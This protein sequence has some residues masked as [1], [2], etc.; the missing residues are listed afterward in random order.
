M[1]HER[2]GMEAMLFACRG[3]VQQHGAPFYAITTERV[4]NFLTLVTT[5]SASELA[6]RFEGY[7]VSGVKGTCIP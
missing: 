5:S 2:T 7:C 6:T 3:G 1:L 4:E